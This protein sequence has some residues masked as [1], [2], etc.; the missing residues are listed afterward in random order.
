M[1]K[2]LLQLIEIRI[3]RDTCWRRALESCLKLVITLCYLTTGDSGKT[4]QYRFLVAHST[5]NLIIPETCEAII[6]E[7][8]EEAIDLPI[9]LLGLLR[10][11]WPS[12]KSQCDIVPTE[13]MDADYEFLYVDI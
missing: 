11:I 4:F 10:S 3:K 13:L 12:S 9:I 5:F 7:Y 8:M 6:A 2:E 1:P